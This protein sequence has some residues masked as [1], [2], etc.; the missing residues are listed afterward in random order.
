MQGVSILFDTQNLLRL[1]EGLVVSTEISFISIFISIIGGLVF[2]V[3]MSMKNKFI[4]FI[5]T[6]CEKNKNGLFF[7]TIAM[8]IIA[9][10]RQ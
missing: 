2:G 10:I 3:L 9:T 7:E 6:I 5:L 8:K 4:Y 1:F